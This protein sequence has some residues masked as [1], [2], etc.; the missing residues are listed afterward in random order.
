MK[1]IIEPKLTDAVILKPGE[2]NKIHF[3]GNHTP[4]TPEKLK[5]LADSISAKAEKKPD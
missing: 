1:R 5:A 4:L 2:M 3:G